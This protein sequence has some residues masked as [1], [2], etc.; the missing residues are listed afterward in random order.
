M[1]DRVLTIEKLRTTRQ[2][3]DEYFGVHAMMLFGSSAKGLQHDG[4]DVHIN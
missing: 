1:L 2:Y 4:S 3:L